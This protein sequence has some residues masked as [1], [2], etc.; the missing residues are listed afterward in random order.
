MTEFEQQKLVGEINNN[1]KM[2]FYLQINKFVLNYNAKSI[3]R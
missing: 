1:K 3:L 2:K